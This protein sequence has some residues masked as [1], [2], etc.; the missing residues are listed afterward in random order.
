[1]IRED[2]KLSLKNYQ[3]QVTF[4]YSFNFHY[5]FSP[6]SCFLCNP[7]LI[8]TFSL[9]FFIGNP[10]ILRILKLLMIFCDQTKPI[11]NAIFKK[12]THIYLVFAGSGSFTWNSKRKKN[13]IQNNTI[14]LD[15]KIMLKPFVMMT[16]I[17]TKSNEPPK[18]PHKLQL[19]VP[20]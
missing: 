19:H 7:P 4:W 10:M 6:F 11:M 8:S 18:Y 13:R 20:N 16:T 14:K 12:W 2:Q 15:P 3:L 1:M 17:P 9:L 5:C